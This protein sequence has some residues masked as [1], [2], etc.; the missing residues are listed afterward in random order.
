MM[1]Y[2]HG[3]TAKTRHG[4]NE[5]YRCG[6]ILAEAYFVTRSGNSETLQ[7]LPVSATHVTA[8][9]AHPNQD[10]GASD[11]HRQYACRDTACQSTWDY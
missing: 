1:A 4:A 9:K 8:P 2:P 5:I 3:R 10:E 6:R 7:K 11:M